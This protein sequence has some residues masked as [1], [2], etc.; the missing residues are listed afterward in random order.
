MLKIAFF[1]ITVWSCISLV[2]SHSFCLKAVSVLWGTPRQILVD[3]GSTLKHFA[4][5]TEKEGRHR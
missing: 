4:I 2:A 1:P 5:K 3:S